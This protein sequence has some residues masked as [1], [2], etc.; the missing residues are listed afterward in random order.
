MHSQ[1]MTEQLVYGVESIIEN[2]LL[3]TASISQQIKTSKEI[4]R[5]RNHLAIL[6]GFETSVNNLKSA[7]L[8]FL[9][10]RIRCL[11]NCGTDGTFVAKPFKSRDL[12][13]IKR[14]SCEILGPLISD[15]FGISPRVTVSYSWQYIMSAFLTIR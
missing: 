2:L 11:A 14:L 4:T 3:R 8:N 13:Y 6:P 1:I 7:H 9:A 10:I 15:I 12:L 5:L